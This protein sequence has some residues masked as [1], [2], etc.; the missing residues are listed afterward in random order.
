M[1]QRAHALHDQPYTLSDAHQDHSSDMF[2]RQHACKPTKHG[3]FV[4]YDTPSG[5]PVGVW[6][7]GW[8]SGLGWAAQW[9]PV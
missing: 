2:S 7:S 4:A 1:P 3:T 5:S 9:A 6:G 8:G